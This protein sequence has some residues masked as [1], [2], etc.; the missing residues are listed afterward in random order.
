MA[1]QAGNLESQVIAMKESGTGAIVGFGCRSFRK[2]F[3]DGQVSTI[4][5]LSGL[6]GL[7]EVRGG[8]LLARAYRYLKQ[9]HG[10]GKVPYYVT[11]IFDDNQHAKTLLESGRAGLP[12][13]LPLGRLRTFLL[14]LYG[15]RKESCG[16]VVRVETDDLLEPAGECINVFNG[17]HQFSP[18]YSTADLKG[19]TTL[20]PCFD[21]SNLYA[22]LRGSKVTATAGVWDQNSFKQTVVAGYSL[23]YR[24]IRP[25]ANAGARMGWSAKLPKVGS[26]FPYLYA[27]FLSHAL[28]YDEDLLS[29]IRQIMADWSQQ[30]FAYLLVGVHEQNPLANQ[31]QQMSA[32]ALSST[33]YMVYWDDA[34]T[35]AL[36]SNNH[37]PHLEIATL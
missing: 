6:R 14:P 23:P 21:H 9:L 17:Q 34:L 7:P 13:Y 19:K 1:E 27:S 32:M 12:T 25:L 10:D 11:T 31:L 18:F 36:P 29:L 28:G 3:V 2:V 30:G 8:T 15:N 35:E 22:Y 26:H 24:F 20:L 37:T 16:K 4:G 33:V 5:Y